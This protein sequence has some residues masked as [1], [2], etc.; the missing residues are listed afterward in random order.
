MPWLSGCVARWLYV[1]MAKWQ[2][3]YE[4]I[5]DHELKDSLL[6]FV[7]QPR[8]P[9]IS[10]TCMPEYPVNFRSQVIVITMVS[11]RIEQYECALALGQDFVIPV[12]T[13]Q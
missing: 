12:I 10:I 1:Y 11:N 4:L 3:G 7:H 9:Y 2:D 5:I 8:F 6:N 13:T